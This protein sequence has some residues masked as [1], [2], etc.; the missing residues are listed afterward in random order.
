VEEIIYSNERV[1]VLQKKARLDGQSLSL[2]ATKNPIGM[3]DLGIA[4]DSVW[5]YRLSSSQIDLASTVMWL[6][7]N[8]NQQTLW[9]LFPNET[10]S[11]VALG[12]DK[13]ILNKLDASCKAMK[14]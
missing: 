5:V 14:K 12:F 3:E 8:P 4:K 11:A 13:E 7:F 6:Q 1:K 10:K 2:Y 9:E